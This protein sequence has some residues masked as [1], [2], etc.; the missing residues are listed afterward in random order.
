M[1]D[2]ACRTSSRATPR[3]SLRVALDIGTTTLVAPLLDLGRPARWPSVRL[4]PQIRF[5][6]D[7]LSR[8]LHARHARRAAAVARTVVRRST[9]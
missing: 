2:A 4:N 8:I 3:P 6:D 7:V 9:R 1:A 5:G